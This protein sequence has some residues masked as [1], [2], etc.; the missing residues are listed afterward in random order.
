M[1]K[2]L[3]FIDDGIQNVYVQLFER[4]KKSEAIL[5]MRFKKFFKTRYFYL[6]INGHLKNSGLILLDLSNSS[7]K[8]QS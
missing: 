2:L 3:I 6:Y 4:G 7:I 8:S 5:T 1:F